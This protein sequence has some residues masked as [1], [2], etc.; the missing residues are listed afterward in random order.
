MLDEYFK[1][2]TATRHN[3]HNYEEFKH[4]FKVNHWS[5]STQNIVRDNLCNG[6][7]DLTRRTLTSYFLGKLCFARNLE[8]KIPECLVNK[9][10]YHF[11]EGIVHILCA[12]ISKPYKQ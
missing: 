8:P 7:Y 12:D 4:L 11:E 5:E 3:L 9:L 10:A 6:K 2:L 1:S